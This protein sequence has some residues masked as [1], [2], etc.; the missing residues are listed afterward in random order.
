M[1]SGRTSRKVIVNSTIPLLKE[2]C[3]YALLTKAAILVAISMHK[4]V[5]LVVYS[6]G[7]MLNIFGSAYY[8]LNGHSWSLAIELFQARLILRNLSHI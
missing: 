7:T 6:K 4:K 2:L 8:T 1:L 5:P 3:Q